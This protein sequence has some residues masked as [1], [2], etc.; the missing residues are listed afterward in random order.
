[1][2]CAVIL[3]QTAQQMLII[4]KPSVSWHV[5]MFNDTQC[6]SCT[7]H[8]LQAYIELTRL[9]KGGPSSG[10]WTGLRNTVLDHNE[11]ISCYNFSVTW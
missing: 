5:I 2:V 9:L 4:Q 1:M 7:A 10:G 8:H 6:Q 11:T 3:F